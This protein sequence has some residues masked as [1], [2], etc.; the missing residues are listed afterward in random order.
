MSYSTL[1]ADLTKHKEL[2]ISLWQ[3]NLKDVS[4]ERFSWIYENNPNGQPK[5]FL[6]LHEESQAVVGAISLFPRP[7][8]YQGKTVKSYI[9]GD[10]VVESQHRSLGP[11]LI[12]L[13]AAIKHCDQEDPCILISLPNE[14]SK[15]V[16]LRV[17]YKILGEYCEFVKVMKTRRYLLRYLKPQALAA[18]FAWPIDVF[19]HCRHD[20]FINAIKSRK[21]KYE[22][23]EQFDSRFNYLLNNLKSNYDLV[24]LRNIDYLN[25][26][27]VLNPYGKCKIFSIFNKTDKN[28]YGYIAYRYHSLRANIID[29]VFAGGDKGFHILLFLFSGFMMNNGADSISISLAGNDNIKLN[30]NS[31]GYYKRSIK[32]KVVI[33]SS[34]DQ[35]NI[36]DIV[37]NSNWYITK[38]DNDV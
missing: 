11:A 6:L 8:V 28:M 31:L 9:C 37:N 38:T 12:L 20:I 30:M 15:P 36:V 34:F 5:V 14:K 24:G 3:N 21:Y 16:A 13:K 27:L 19:L 33:Y 1:P 32:N 22:I 2:L 29:I 35:A 25:W 26:R 10:M 23:F 17:G 18:L 4:P 7:F